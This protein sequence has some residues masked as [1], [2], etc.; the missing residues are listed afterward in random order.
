MIL[1]YKKRNLGN[2]TEV[3]YHDTVINYLHFYSERRYEWLHVII[4]LLP[5]T[6]STKTLTFTEDTM[7]DFIITGAYRADYNY[8][9]NFD[10]N[11]NVEIREYITQYEH[12][13]DEE[14]K[15]GIHKFT[16]ADGTVFEEQEESIGTLNIATENF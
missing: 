7:N 9:P 11:V 4:I 5:L 16:R 10:Q 14:R 3:G 13:F 15:C 8:H 1:K 2:V 12:Y 6:G